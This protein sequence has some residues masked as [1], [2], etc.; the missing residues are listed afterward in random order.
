[1]ATGTALEEEV[2]RLAASFHGQ[3]GVWAQD[4]RT[5][6][7]VARWADVP[8]ETASTIKVLI[9]VEVYRQA[10]QG[11]LS[12]S[13]PLTL[14]PQHM[15]TGSGVLR[16]LT[17]GLRLSIRDACA[18]MMGVSDNVATNMLLDRVGIQGVE[19]LAATWGLTHTRLFGPLHFDREPAA[20]VGQSTPRELGDVMRRLALGQAVSPE[21]DRD[22]LALMR[23]NQY[24]TA[25]T[26]HLPYELLEEPA[27]GQ[28]PVLRV[29]SKSG[30]WEGVRAIVGYLW[31]PGTAYVVSL[32]SQGCPDRRMHVDNEAMLVLP[33]VSRL[34]FDA[35]AD[36]AALRQA[37]GS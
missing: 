20:G 11:Q 27:P 18:L 12:L 24:D 10:A 7:Q 26:R 15:V 35:F 21:A 31:G 36:A 25:L 2:E 19:R 17:P 13:E 4:L 22:M 33:Q 30:T 16:D 1:M 29:A 3:L 23:R 6:R 37:R 5:G 32:M 28:D 9:L 14:A 8:F 34:V